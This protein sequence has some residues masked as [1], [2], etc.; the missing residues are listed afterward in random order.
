MEIE[1]AARKMLLGVP[2]VTGYVQ[3]KVF[4]FRLEEKVDGT[5]GRAIVVERNNGWASPDTV[6]SQEYP[7]LRIKMF[8]DPD[9]E[10]SGEIKM[11]NAEEK[12]WAMHRVVDPL[13][14]GKRG[15]VWGASES[16]SGLLVVTARRWKEPVLVGPHDLHGHPSMDPLGDSVYVEADY[17]LQVVH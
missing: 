10:S 14:H 13:I 8:A 9:R 7:I 6:T 11:L 15:M 17:A 3:Q 4:K 5:G 16:N 1:T 12:A 2:A